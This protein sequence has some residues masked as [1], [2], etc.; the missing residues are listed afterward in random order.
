[1]AAT[2]SPRIFLSHAD[3]DT[4]QVRQLAVALQSNGAQ[5]WF[6]EWEL[7]PGD[8][9]VQKISAGLEDCDVFLI[10]I[11]QVSVTRK[12]VKEE[13]S[14]AVVRRI[15]EKTRLIPVLLDETPLPA[16]INHLIYVK[17][18][19]LDQA[20]EKI[21]KAAHGIS[22]KP[23]VGKTPDFIRRGLE[24]RDT[25]TAGLGPEATAVLRELVREA[26]Q[27]DYPFDMYVST[28]GVQQVLGLNEVDMDDAIDLL[29]ERGLIKALPAFGSFPEVQVQARA[30]VYVMDDLNFDLRDAMLRVAS[31]AVAQEEPVDAFTLE[32]RSGL[33]I[34]AL[35][36][37]VRVLET[38]DRLDVYYGGMGAG[39]PHGFVQVTATRKTRE[40]VRSQQQ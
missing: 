3:A 22:D 18:Y 2:T 26:R 28:Q 13:L 39:R 5:V 7:L 11:S 20:V 29:K 31:A 35:M 12:W 15:E 38:L 6:D 37:A 8:S 1:M 40:W 27:N 23:P 36:A 24:R 10:A 17:L 32:Q 33:S 9:L 25:S 16:L 14:S 34:E 21:L 30:W 4:D 19:P